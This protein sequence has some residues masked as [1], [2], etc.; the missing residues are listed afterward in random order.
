[1]TDD[2]GKCVAHTE[3]DLHPI[4]PRHPELEYKCRQQY[5][6]MVM[7]MDEV[8]GNVTDALKRR[9]M[10]DNTLVVMS[11]DNGGAIEVEESAATNWPLRGGKYSLF[12]GGIRVAAFVS[13]GL[14]P[15]QLRGSVNNGMIHVADWYS[16]FAGLAGVDPTDTLAAAS[17]LPPIDSLDMWPFLSGKTQQS[18]RDS[19]PIA[20]TCLVQGDWKLIT[21]K[22]VPDNWQ[23]PLSPNSSTPAA[24]QGTVSSPGHCD[25]GCLFNVVDDPTEQVNL[26]SDHPEIVSKMK[27]DLEN[28]KKSFF[29]NRDSFQND[30]PEGTEN[31][32]CWM[33]KNRYGGFLGPY[34]MTSP[35]LA[36]V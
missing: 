24:L 2:E 32:A 8:I 17:G 4:D 21:N 3:P 35:E 20:S 33:A 31:C 1:M 12:E 5:H 29:G 16:T 15:Q 14:V 23:G 19:I 9:G 6:A 10:W 11:S 28:A 18:P 7:V 25:T 22:T 36:L 13:G 26:F 34:A 27:A 30:C